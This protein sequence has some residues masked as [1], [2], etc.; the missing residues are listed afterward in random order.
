MQG[1]I[2][3]LSGITAADVEVFVL[4]DRREHT[5]LLTIEAARGRL[6]NDLINYFM[7]LGR[8]ALLIKAIFQQ[9]VVV[10]FSAAKLL[11][12]RNGSSLPLK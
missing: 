1:L 3:N 12:L 8:L 4:E 6:L 11:G 10:E 2:N 9:G 5:A 7:L